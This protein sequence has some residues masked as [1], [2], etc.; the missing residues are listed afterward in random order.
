MFLFLY[1]NTVFPAF[2]FNNKKLQITS[3]PGHNSAED[4]L[5]T[6]VLVNQTGSNEKMLNGN[7]ND[8]SSKTE[9]IE[10]DAKVFAIN[11]CE[12]PLKVPLYHP[13][14]PLMSISTPF[15]KNHLRRFG[16]QKPQKSRP[17]PNK[18]AGSRKT[19]PQTRV[20][21]TRSNALA[22]VA[23]AQRHQV[24]KVKLDHL[25]FDYFRFRVT[26]TLLFSHLHNGFTKSKRRQLGPISIWHLLPSFWNVLGSAYH[27]FLM[28][29]A[30]PC[31]KHKEADAYGTPENCHFPDEND[32]VQSIQNEAD[33]TTFSYRL[34]A[35]RARKRSCPKA[36]NLITCFSIMMGFCAL[37]HLP[38]V[39][40]EKQSSINAFDDTDFFLRS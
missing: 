2:F 34:T 6:S 1:F 4:A 38:L 9:C 18:Q 33:Q 11:H 29:I 24:D 5:S 39:K 35:N 37:L 12:N 40:A 30:G 13:P 17:K 15:S 36:W 3:F 27:Y 31:A 20:L 7:K 14:K 21:V 22:S 16:C 23:P 10:S 8:V 28:K 32:C 26:L 25:D 19:C